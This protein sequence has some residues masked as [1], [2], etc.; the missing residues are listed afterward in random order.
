MSHLMISSAYH[1]TIASG[2]RSEKAGGFPWE[3]EGGE[4]SC[5]HLEAD[6]HFGH[7]T[8]QYARGAQ[9]ARDLDKAAH[10]DGAQD[11][12]FA[13]AVVAA[14]AGVVRLVVE[15]GDAHGE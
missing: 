10:A 9:D 2:G 14:A 4:G 12:A 13:R 7:P 6:G 3:S 8:R 5:A 15:C 11:H 1:V